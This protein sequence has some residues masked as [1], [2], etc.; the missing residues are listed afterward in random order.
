MTYRER[1]GLGECRVPGCTSDGNCVHTCRV[2]GYVI[3]DGEREPSGLCLNCTPT[4]PADLAERMAQALE[5]AVSYWVPRS[6][7]WETPEKERAEQALAEYRALVP[8][9]DS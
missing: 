5:V 1:A 3:W 7:R 4:I 8:K 9:L 2:C 6:E